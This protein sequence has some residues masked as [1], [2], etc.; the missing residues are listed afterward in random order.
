MVAKKRAIAGE[1]PKQRAVEQEPRKRRAPEEA[2]THLLDAAERLFAERGPDAVGLRDVARQAGVSH[3]LI[4]HYFK[5]YEGLV[6][7]VFHRRAERIAARVVSRFAEM[8]ETPSAAE[9]VDLM[10]SIASEPVHLRLVAWSMLSGRAL[11]GGFAPGRS[12]EPI[13][14]AILK[15]ATS[16]AKRRGTRAPSRDDVDYALLLMLGAAYGWGLGKV[17]FLTALGR[18]ATARTDH[19]VLA[20]LTTM[21]RALL[22]P[23]DPAR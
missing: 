14:E 19:E 10:L 13:A 5:T 23:S 12:L 11:R 4:T 21:V 2:R 22:A 9:L 6:E 1:K 16:E 17:P 8:N 15:A 18:K 7:A 3:G 20:R